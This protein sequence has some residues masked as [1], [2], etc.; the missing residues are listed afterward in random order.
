MEHAVKNAAGCLSDE[1]TLEVSRWDEEE[2]VKDG[3]HKLVEEEVDA[4]N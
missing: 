3:E 1:L 4:D 2:I